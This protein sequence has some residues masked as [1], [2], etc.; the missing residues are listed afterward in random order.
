M[1][2]QW[3]RLAIR[4]IAVSVGRMT[5]DEM[6]SRI[7]ILA[8]TKCYGDALALAFIAE[9]WTV[10][11][12]SID[13]DAIA[14]AI[15]SIYNVDRLYRMCEEIKRDIGGSPPPMVTQLSERD[16]HDALSKPP[17]V[18]GRPA[19]HDRGSRGVAADHGAG[20]PPV[21]DDGDPPSVEGW[22]PPAVP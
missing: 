18:L 10:A 11:D 3:V 4:E 16:V 9:F 8:A 17:V 19:A 2:H 5:P 15:S 7:S 13:D 22:E 20:D 14:H 6:A 12:Q 21:P 1:T